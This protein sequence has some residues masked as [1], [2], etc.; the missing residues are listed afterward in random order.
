MERDLESVSFDLD[1]RE[2]FP[3]R[4][5]S[6]DAAFEA[7]YAR[8]LDELERRLLAEP[9]VTAVTFASR[10]PLTYHPW[11][12]VEL[13]V[14]MAEPPEHGRHL[15]GSEDVDT[16]FFETMQGGV[17][18][19]RPLDS[20]D[21][22]SG[23]RVVV[24]DRRFA[25]VVLGGRN[26]VGARLR[27]LAVSRGPPPEP[28]A[29]WYEIVGMVENLGISRESG[30]VYH[31]AARGSVYPASMLLRL[32]ED[33]ADFAPRLRSLAADMDA[34]RRATTRASTPGAAPPSS[35]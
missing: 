34:T 27:Y 24:V 6:D 32:R 5:G 12:E 17:L 20:E 15:V 10:T 9:T 29:P 4:A 26:P 18:A 25:D 31:P 28:D 13:D 11:N 30:G 19:G 35:R 16:G 22:V 14:P 3:E 33:P 8:T 21:G 23:A 7:R 2:L 1:T